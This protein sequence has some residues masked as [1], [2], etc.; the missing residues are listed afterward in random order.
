MERAIALPPM[1]MQS[2]KITDITD[3]MLTVFKSVSDINSELK[4][5][6]CMDV[7]TEFLLTGLL[8]KLRQVGLGPPKENRSTFLPAKFLSCHPTIK[9]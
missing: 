6:V 3:G 8:S 2:V 5:H 9:H 4:Q 1:L 7:Y